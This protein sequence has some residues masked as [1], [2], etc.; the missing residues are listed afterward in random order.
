MRRI[1]II[2]DLQNDFIDAT[3]GTKEAWVFVDAA[4]CAGVTPD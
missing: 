1:L 3:L 4:C 2:I